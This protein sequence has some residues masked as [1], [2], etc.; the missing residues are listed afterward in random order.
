MGSPVLSFIKKAHRRADIKP[1]A[2]PRAVASSM[3]AAKI[4]SFRGL[5][6]AAI[7][8]LASMLHRQTARPCLRRLRR[9]PGLLALNL[10]KSLR[11]AQTH[12]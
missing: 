2:M 6:K 9:H 11:R 10:A 3:A 5:V 7:A 8:W 12:K 1:I 4:A